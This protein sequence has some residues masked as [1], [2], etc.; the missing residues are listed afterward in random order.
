MCI[1]FSGDWKNTILSAKKVYWRRELFFLPYG[2]NGYGP[3]P[4]GP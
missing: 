2:P 3:C 4:L 1:V